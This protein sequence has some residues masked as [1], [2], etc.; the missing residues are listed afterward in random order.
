VTDAAD[1]VCLARLGQFADPA[2]K[3]W[4]ITAASVGRARECGIPAEQILGWL[5]DHL[6]HE[7]PP[8]IETAIRN[9]S[10]PAGVFLGELVML[11]VGQPQACAMMQDSPRFRS[12]LQ[13]F[14]PP[15]WFVVRQDKRPELERLLTELGFV[16]G[17]SWKPSAVPDRS[18]TVDSPPRESSGRKPRKRRR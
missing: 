18:N 10:G 14:F 17:A 11:Q 6:S 13:D 5:E 9:W 2:G 8:V 3:G 1:S 12:L 7:L 16:V 4:V 15:N